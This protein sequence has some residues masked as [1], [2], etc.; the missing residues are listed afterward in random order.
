M[1]QTAH[2]AANVANRKLLILW[3]LLSMSELKL[4]SVKERLQELIDNKE[5]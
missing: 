5:D 3:I 1:I 4:S 2:S